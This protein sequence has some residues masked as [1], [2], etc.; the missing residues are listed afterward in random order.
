MRARTPRRPHGKTVRSSKFAE[1]L[2]ATGYPPRKAHELG[3]R[4]AA[5]PRHAQD[6]DGFNERTSASLHGDAVKAGEHAV[7]WS[8]HARLA[9]AEQAQ[10]QAI[11]EKFPQLHEQESSARAVEQQRQAAAAAAEQRRQTAAQY[12]HT[13]YTAPTPTQS[14]PGMSL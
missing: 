1:R 4:L 2:G 7:Y 6:I 11:A 14:G 13:S 12:D 8:G 5:L 9:Q 10:R 3:E